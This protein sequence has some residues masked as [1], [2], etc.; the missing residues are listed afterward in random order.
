MRNKSEFDEVSKA[1][2][3]PQSVLKETA[4]YRLP[5]YHPDYRPPTPEEAA[6]HK[7]NLL[8]WLKDFQGVEEEAEQRVT[9]AILRKALGMPTAEE[10]AAMMRG[11]V[12]EAV[13]TVPC[14][15]EP[16]RPESQSGNDSRGGSKSMAT[17]LKIGESITR[18]PIPQSVLKETAPYRLPPYHPDYRDPTPEEAEEEKASFL[19]WWKDFEGCES[20]DEQRETAEILRK[21]L[22]I[23]TAEEE[24]AML[25]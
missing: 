4:P 16:V 2:P 5:N 17:D 1:G 18:G 19:A 12:Y 10:E 25:R 20:A 15:H 21:A 3:I 8:A 23:P 6:A 14:D 9:M 24:R 22:G 13:A 11:S 7:S